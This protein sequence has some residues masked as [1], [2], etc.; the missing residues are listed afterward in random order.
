MAKKSRTQLQADA[1]NVNVLDNTTQQITPTKVRDQYGDERDSVL[2]YVDDLTGSVGDFLT[3]GADGES[4]AFV[5]SGPAGGLDGEIQVNDGGALNGTTAIVIDG[6]SNIE[7]TN[8]LEVDTITNKAGSGAPSFTNGLASE[9]AITR[10]GGDVIVTGPMVSGGFYTE[11][12]QQSCT[13]AVNTDIRTFTI[14]NIGAYILYAT[15]DDGTIGGAMQLFFVRESDADIV[16]L[17]KTSSGSIDTA[18]SGNTLQLYQSTGVTKTLN[19]TI[20][21]F[22]ATL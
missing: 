10:S 4:L 20:T 22:Y 13:N 19:W 1:T 8:T 15:F 11:S 16:L 5:N 6:S 18:S 17:T 12:G 21:R 2:N 3:I 14:A 9:G 7:I